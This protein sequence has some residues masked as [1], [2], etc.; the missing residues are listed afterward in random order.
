MYPELGTGF[1]ELK[2]KDRRKYDTIAKNLDPYEY[3]IISMKL[4][5]EGYDVQ[6]AQFIEGQHLKNNAKIVAE[7][8][9]VS[10]RTE[11]GAGAQA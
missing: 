8:Y 4:M 10:Y 3:P 7:S 2:Q 6:N 5:A 1:N 11:H 9:L